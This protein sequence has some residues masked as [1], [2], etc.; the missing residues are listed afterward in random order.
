MSA[1]K[2]CLQ[3]HFLDLPF[4]DL[5]SYITSSRTYLCLEVMLKRCK[6]TYFLKNKDLGCNK[7]F[8][9]SSLFQ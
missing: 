2:C 6:L 1:P 8:D 7:L 5:F 9:L 4:V 3:W